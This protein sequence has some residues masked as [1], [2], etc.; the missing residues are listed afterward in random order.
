[1]IPGIQLRK[2]MLSLGMYVVLVAIPYMLHATGIW[3]IAVLLNPFTVF[4]VMFIAVLISVATFVP[5]NPTYLVLFIFF[6]AL[7]IFIYVWA[8]YINP[9]IPIPVIPTS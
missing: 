5:N 2:G 4:F 6:V 9:S 1:M 3:S 7:V 8:L